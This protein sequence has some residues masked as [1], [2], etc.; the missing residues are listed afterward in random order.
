[1]VI[2]CTVLLAIS[3]ALLEG[4]SLHEASESLQGSYSSE[5]DVTLQQDTK[6]QGS[7]ERALGVANLSGHGITVSCSFDAEEPHLRGEHLRVKG[8]FSPA[9]FSNDEYAWSQ[10]ALGTVRVRS[11]SATLGDSI[12]QPLLDVRRSAIQALNGNAESAPRAIL[13]ALVC[14]YRHDIDAFPEYASFQAC[15]L[16]HLVAVS[17]AHLVIVTGLFIALLKALHVSRGPIALAA[18]AIIGS[19]LVVSGMPVSAV[20]AAFMSSIGLLAFF[21]K[22]R[23]SSLNALGIGIVLIVGPRPHEAL[24]VSLAL[25]ALSTAGIVIFSPLVDSW[26]AKTP[27]K[28]VPFASEALSLTLSASIMSQP[29][30]TSVFSVLPLVSP[31]ANVL[32]A[33]LFP[34]ICT[35]GLI[36]ALVS[37]S[38]LPF[39]SAAITICEVMVGIMDKLIAVLAH[40]PFACI[41]FSLG[42]L[43]ALSFSLGL[44]FALWLA[45]TRIRLAHAFAFIAACFLMVLLWPALMPTEDAIVMLDVGQGDAFLLRS[46]GATLLID[47]GNQDRRLISELAEEHVRELDA[48]LI[49]HADDD[50]CGSL[51]ALDRFVQVKRIFVARGIPA[52]PDESCDELCEQARALGNIEEASLGSKISIGAFTCTVVWPAELTDNGGNAD[53]LCVHVAYDGNDDGTVDSTALFTGDAEH[54]EIARILN[55]APLGPLD[56]LKVG[57]HGSRNALTADQVDALKP[58][59]ALI[60]VG[61]NNRYGH[62]APETLDLLETRETAVFRTDING[63]VTCTF[64]PNG[65]SVKPEIAPVS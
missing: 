55:A 24:S 46:R 5:F 56:V 3:L 60:G 23:P 35:C 53:S 15:G 50:H 54:D 13:A 62:P 49:T 43:E 7:R 59:I 45:W 64:T 42:T 10:A 57:H 9:D 20:R 8:T 38:N 39:A 16:A 32:V 47:T 14:G 65:I 48:V 58:R 36:A 11:A 37:V 26:F 41:P 18:V 33:P 17:G 29:F 6:L 34:L 44:A 52:C 21:G 12:V 4:W 28:R 63:T 25:S 61:A 22:R 40:I 30:A 19:Y 51:D 27:L 2:V 1:M 31:L